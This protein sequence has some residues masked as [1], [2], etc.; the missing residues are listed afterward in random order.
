MRRRNGVSVELKLGPS[1]LGG[2]PGRGKFLIEIAATDN[3]R[4]FHFWPR[5]N[6]LANWVQ[7]TDATPG[8]TISSEGPEGV[9]FIDVESQAGVPC[10]RLSMVGIF[11]SAVAMVP[12]SRLRRHLKTAIEQAI[13]AGLFSDEQA[14]PETSPTERP[15]GE[16]AEEPIGPADAEPAPKR[17]KLNNLGRRARKTVSLSHTHCNRK[18]SLSPHQSS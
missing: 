5:P 17:K 4:R 14:T 9:A 18:H 6:S 10:Y 13:V 7:L 11:G 8:M 2:Q 3:C 16:L 1:I 15:A 12:I